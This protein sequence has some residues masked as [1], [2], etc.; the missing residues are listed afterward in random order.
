M[1]QSRD[2]SLVNTLTLKNSKPSYLEMIVYCIPGFG[3][4]EKIFNNLALNAD[5]RFINWLDP[6][7]G[8]SLRQY[9]ERM[10]SS[11][12]GE[13][14]VILGI[15]FGGMIAQEIAKFRR[16]KQIIL[17]SSIKSRKELPKHLRITGR[18]RLD[19]LFP[20]KKIPDNEKAFKLANKRLG[21]FTAE[22]QLMANR[23]RRHANLNY[24]N[25]SFDK[26]LNWKNDQCPANTIHI[27]GN[28]DR[29]F[30]IKNIKP[31][32]V[33]DNGTHMMVWNRA[34]EISKII[35]EVLKKL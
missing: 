20:V 11:I 19:K 5:L 16:V 7:K 33:I 8:E 35:N 28:K 30:S 24:V 14:V 2:C 21:A 27:H 25:W 23:Y 1:G 6:L 12:D 32:H 13:D 4:D 3:V 26:I 9:A 34:G 18:L 22:E 17:V 15:S 29:V 31:T 10:A